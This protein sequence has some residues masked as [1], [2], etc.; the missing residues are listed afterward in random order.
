M[1]ATKRCISDC[2]ADLEAGFE[3]KSAAVVYSCSGLCGGAAVATIYHWGKQN[4]LEGARMP[5][6]THFLDAFL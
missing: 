2:G 3:S 4:S 1:T 5:S 6:D